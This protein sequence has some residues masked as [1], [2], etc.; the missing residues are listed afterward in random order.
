MWPLT[1][2]NMLRDEDLAIFSGK[3][4]THLL[5]SLGEFRLLLVFYPSWAIPR[6]F[7]WWFL[8]FFQTCHPGLLVFPDGQ[9][10]WLGPWSQ[11]Q[12]APF[13]IQQRQRKLVASTE[14]IWIVHVDVFNPK[15]V[16]PILLFPSFVYIMLNCFRHFF[17]PWQFGKWRCPKPRKKHPFQASHMY[18]TGTSVY[19]S[20]WDQSIPLPF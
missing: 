15:M 14:F 13:I 4:K 11:H 6:N 20:F 9:G 12:V 3:I 16:N 2:V 1:V 10:P 18:Q 5:P 17:K 7:R 19:A 8:F